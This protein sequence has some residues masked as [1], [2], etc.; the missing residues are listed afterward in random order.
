M[1][2][3]GLYSIGRDGREGWVLRRCRRQGWV[4]RPSIAERNPSGPGGAARSG[5]AFEAHAA[6]AHSRRKA[7]RPGAPPEKLE[8][9][10]VRCRERAGPARLYSVRD[11]PS[12][13]ELELSVEVP[14][15]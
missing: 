4:Q 13:A 2:P 1:T 14:V 9:R 15:A 11:A 8:A 3:R 6:L 10:V 7:G 5:V 12:R